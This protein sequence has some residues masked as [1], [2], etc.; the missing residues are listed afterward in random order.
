MN[1]KLPARLAPV[2]AS[3]VSLLACSPFATEQ[4]ASPERAPMGRASVIDGDTLEIHGRRIRLDGIDAPEAG[5]ACGRRGR[6]WPCGR[7]AA[8]ALAAFIADR[9]VRCAGG[10]TD[11]YGRLIARCRVGRTDLSAW[12]VRNGWAMA[13]RRYSTAYV[14]AEDQAR[15]AKR[16]IWQGPFT[17][18]WD[19][20]RG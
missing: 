5:Q 13:Y 11:R 18:P 20:R 7:R 9:P 14:D 15:A 3:V 12:M 2:V 4:A 8:Q 10:T 17:A 1:K 6:T 19:Y 16:G